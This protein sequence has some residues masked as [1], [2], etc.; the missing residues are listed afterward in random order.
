MLHCFRPLVLVLSLSLVCLWSNAKNRQQEQ[1]S[2]QDKYL[3][4]RFDSINVFEIQKNWEG[5]IDLSYRIENYAELNS[6]P[7]VLK[8]MLKLRAESLL[9]IGNFNQALT[10]YLRLL[11]IYEN[12]GD[13]IGMA[14][15]LNS[16][17]RVYTQLGNFALALKYLYQG[18]STTDNTSDFYN[19]A[20][21]FYSASL[22]HHLQNDFASCEFCLREAENLA[23]LNLISELKPS[24]QG[25]WGLIFVDQ[26][27]Y[28]Q[29]QKL[30]TQS[31]DSFKKLGDTLSMADM[32][33]NMGRLSM[34]QN[35]IGE[36]L[37]Y[38]YQALSLRVK[39]RDLKSLAELY[40]NLAET[41]L[42]A[43]NS[44]SSLFYADKSMMLADAFN[45]LYQ[46]SITAS[47]ISRIYQ[48]KGEWEQ[49]YKWAMKHNNTHN[50]IFT[51]QNTRAIVQLEANHQF[52]KR[53]NQQILEQEKAELILKE[54][55]KRSKIIGIY[56]G[57]TAVL[58][59]LAFFIALRS[60]NTKRKHTKLLEEQKEEILVQNE[61]ILAQKESLFEMNEELLQKNETISANLDKIEQQ[62]DSLQKLTHKL[63]EKAQL[64]EKQ[65]DIL[66]RQKKELTDSIIYAERIQQACLPTKGILQDVFPDSFVFYRPKNIISGDFY[67]VN[68]VRGYKIFAIG[69]CTGHG[70]PGG[71]LSMLG[72]A[73]LNNI[74]NKEHITTS[75][76]VLEEM[77]RQIIQSLHQYDWQAE[78]ENNDG[79]DMAVCAL[80]TNTM[81]LQ[82]S[83]ANLPIYIFKKNGNNNGG[84][85]S[86]PIVLREDRMPISQYIKT[87]PFSNKSVKVERG[88]MVYMFTDGFTDQFG[89][90]DGRKFNASRFRSLLSSIQHYDT[91]SQHEIVARTFDSWK[92]EH[93]QIDDVLVMGIRI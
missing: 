4:Q 89:D 11:S 92:G 18:I 20:F 83:G 1:E 81:E 31:F 78:A 53:L 84:G 73:Y 52:E 59:F 44:D 38:H 62:R 58:A 50:S 37:E 86:K 40:Q 87:Q 55:A 69:D 10:S 36:S 76:E 5:I 54:K 2:T 90:N 34:L 22:V 41:Y 3:V 65:R 16:I 51:P 39:Q 15:T 93:P 88:D 30:F 46:Q 63:Q 60:Y 75:S 13:S 19:Q 29:A 56:L 33:N 7:T 85:H 24:I 64:I 21:L 35:R 61:E 26:K 49:A 67:L 25:V 66:F 28:N 72:I 12:D 48:S 9:S 91:A 23:K 32:L 45:L 27:K 74:I 77:R 70:V 14:K 8:Q 68:N 79:M 82:Y 43:G 17:G 57:T 80:N 71:L 42:K 6:N 47:L